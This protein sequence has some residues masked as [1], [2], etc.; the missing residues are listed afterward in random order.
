MELYS[1]L[2]LYVVLH[3]NVYALSD[4]TI[5]E[6]LMAVKE[7]DNAMADT[8]Y[9]INRLN[10]VLQRL[11]DPSCSNDDECIDDTRMELESITNEA[12]MLKESTIKK[13]LNMLMVNI[14]LYAPIA[15]TIAAF[16][17]TILYTN[18]K[19]Y[20]RRKMME[21]EVKEVEEE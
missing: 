21:M 1:L 11:N 16:V 9:L 12:M 7:A 3:A 10:S 13:N 8:S 20:L 6:A 19:S 4:V 14:L 2:L 5:D 18:L 17:I 15:A